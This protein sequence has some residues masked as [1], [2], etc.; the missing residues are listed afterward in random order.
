MIRFSCPVCQ[1]HLKAPDNKGGVKV[2]CPK[3]GQRLQIPPPQRSKTMLGEVDEVGSKS[4]IELSG[5][6]TAS[7]PAATR[8]EV[9]LDDLGPSDV[10]QR[11]PRGISRCPFCDSTFPPL[12][13]KQVSPAGWV[14]F[15]TVI[16]M[17][18]GMCIAGLCLWPLIVVGFV[19]MPLSVLGI[20]ITTEYRVCSDC[21]AKLGD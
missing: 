21:G 1:K 16:A 17:G 18:F 5:F 15:S 6:R 4:R 12:M 11:R 7:Q 3:C 14:V 20:L 2:D 9:E 8:T 13:K 19:C 10:S